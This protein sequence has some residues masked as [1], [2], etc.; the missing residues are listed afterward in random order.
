VVSPAVPEGQAIIRT[1]YTAIHSDEQLEFVL[2]TFEKVGKQLGIIPGGTRRSRI[3]KLPPAKRWRFSFSRQEL[4]S[5]SK[6]WTKH[7]WWF[8]NK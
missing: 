5:A 7:L 6:R 8:N 3:M 2:D 4:A 1:S